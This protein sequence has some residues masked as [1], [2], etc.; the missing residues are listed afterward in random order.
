L[1]TEHHDVINEWNGYWR[2]DRSWKETGLGDIVEGMTL[3]DLHAPLYVAV[4]D[5]EL[6]RTAKPGERIDVPLVASFLSGNTAF[7]DSL[8]LRAELYGVNAL[9]ERRTYANVVRRIPYK[10]WMAAPLE[11]LSVTMPS[12]PAVVVLAVRLED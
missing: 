6:S 5:P 9:G 8:V 1:Y 4:G 2:F 10:P 7:G 12:E 11:P 3:R